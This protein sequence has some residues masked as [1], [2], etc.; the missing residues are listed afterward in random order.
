MNEG[1]GLVSDNNELWERQLG[2]QV[3]LLIAVTSKMS[4]S[5][6]MI[7]YQAGKTFKRKFNFHF[8]G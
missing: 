1:N 6:I 7:H 2:S 5:N 8:V 3:Q 4:F